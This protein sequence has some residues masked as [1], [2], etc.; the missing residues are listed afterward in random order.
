MCLLADKLY[1]VSP[2]VVDGALGLY[3]S[4]C[5]LRI[6]MCLYR[7]LTP[8]LGTLLNFMNHR[9]CNSRENL[10]IFFDLYLMIFYVMCG[11]TC[12]IFLH[13]RDSQGDI[14]PSQSLCRHPLVMLAA[15]PMYI[16]GQILSLCSIRNKTGGLVPSCFAGPWL[17]GVIMFD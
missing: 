16:F 6:G 13:S 9:S 14:P 3:V 2:C 10:E 5:V 17:Y 11:V 15:S 1:S 8:S 7:S 4:P 12:Q